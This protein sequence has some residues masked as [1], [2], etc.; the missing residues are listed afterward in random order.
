MARLRAEKSSG[1]TEALFMWH[2]FRVLV[3]DREEL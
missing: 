2:T 1:S 3:N